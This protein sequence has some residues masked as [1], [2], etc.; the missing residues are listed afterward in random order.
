MLKSQ[1]KLIE[2]L[3]KVEPALRREIEG[4]VCDLVQ[5]IVE[6]TESRYKKTPA[7]LDYEREF[8]DVQLS[9]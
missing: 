4:R 5:E 7:E 6:Q 8:D 1:Q 9:R 2:S 3:S